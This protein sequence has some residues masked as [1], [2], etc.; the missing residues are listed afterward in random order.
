ML[1][2]PFSYLILLTLICSGNS[3]HAQDLKYS[4][5]HKLWFVDKRSE[6]DVYRMRILS[7][8]LRN[9]NLDLRLFY[10]L[11][12]LLPDIGWTGPIVSKIPDRIITLFS[13]DLGKREFWKALA[14][15]TWIRDSLNERAIREREILSTYTMDNLI[16]ISQEDVISNSEF[17]ELSD[18]QVLEDIIQEGRLAFQAIK[19]LARMQ[20]ILPSIGWTGW[21]GGRLPHSIST[22]NGI[23]GNTEKREEFEILSA[24]LIFLMIPPEKIKEFGVS[25]WIKTMPNLM[26]SKKGN[27]RIIDFYKELN[28]Q[29]AMYAVL[30]TKWHKQGYSL[31]Q[32]EKRMEELEK[33]D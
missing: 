19:V 28:A 12:E 24:G 23:F 9:N 16:P 17:Q 33:E 3:L 4:K 2:K 30:V 32:I 15:L 7:R 14:D 18:R 10:K 1:K 27:R 25:Y 5:K 13:G 20:E 8:G 26:Y 21:I 6:K 31:R 11:R 22:L 29:R